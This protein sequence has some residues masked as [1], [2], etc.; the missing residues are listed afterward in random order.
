MLSRSQINNRVQS[1]VQNG[2]SLEEASFTVRNA[3]RQEL[4]KKRIKEKKALDALDEIIENETQTPDDEQ[5]VRSQPAQ[6]KVNGTKK[7]TGKTTK[8]SGNSKGTA[9]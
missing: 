6:E 4:A 7:N 3:I 8:R 1:L 2:A 9:R 5:I